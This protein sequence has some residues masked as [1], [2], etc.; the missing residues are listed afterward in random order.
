MG[1]A[2]TL[3]LQPQSLDPRWQL[4][5]PTT[6]HGTG[7]VPTETLLPLSPAQPTALCTQL[8]PKH[9]PGATETTQPKN[10]EKMIF[11]S[12]QSITISSGLTYSLLEPQKSSRKTLG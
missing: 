8:P 6:R 2:C 4:K 11:I 10:K 12:E 3:V 5:R 7:L 9:I 1:R